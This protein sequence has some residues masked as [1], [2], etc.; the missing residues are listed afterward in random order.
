MFT[1]EILNDIGAALKIF[2]RKAFGGTSA[3][4]RNASVIAIICNTVVSYA[5][6]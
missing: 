2:C 6:I 1:E 5:S 3:A 4:N